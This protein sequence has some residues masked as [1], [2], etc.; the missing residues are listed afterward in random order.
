MFCVFPFELL[1]HYRSA[2]LTV[3]EIYMPRSASLCDLFPSSH[4]FR[5]KYYVF[6]FQALESNP[7]YQGEKPRFIVEISNGEI[8]CILNP[9]CDACGWLSSYSGWLYPRTKTLVL[10]VWGSGWA[11]ALFWTKWWIKKSHCL[12]RNYSRLLV[13]INLFTSRFKWLQ[14][15]FA[16]DILFAWNLNFSTWFTKIINISG[17]KKDWMID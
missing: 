13:W 7:L 9:A 15:T 1:I 6:C 5:S 14:S 4:C 8:P 16:Y 11:Q 17:T 3:L 10:G 12:I 2:C